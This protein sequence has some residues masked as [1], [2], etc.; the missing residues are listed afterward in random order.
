MRTAAVAFIALAFS[1][2]APGSVV[3]GFA[4]DAQQVVEVR[5]IRRLQK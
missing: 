2:Q 1:G 5:D 3:A 4:C